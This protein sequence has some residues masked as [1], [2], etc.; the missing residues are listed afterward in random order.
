ISVNALCLGAVNTEM[1]QQAFPGYTAPV[2][3]QKM[4]EFIFHFMTTA[5]PVMSGKVIPVTMTD[6]KVE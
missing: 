2:S 5:H 1:L 6:P 4:A 3:P